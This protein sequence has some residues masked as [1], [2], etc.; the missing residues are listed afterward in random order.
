MLLAV[1]L[2]GLSGVVGAQEPRQPAGG[3]FL[4]ATPGMADPNFAE[5][6]VLL[7]DCGPEG[8]FGLIVN[9]PT[10]ASVGETFPETPELSGRTD[11]VHFGGPVARG[12]ILA[13]VAAG[14]DLPDSR[15]V[16]DG[17]RLCWSLETLRRIPG[18]TQARLFAGHSGWGPGQLDHEIGRGDWS[19]IPADAATVFDGS[20]GLWL[21]LRRRT[22]AVTVQ[23]P[24]APRSALSPEPVSIR[25]QIGGARDGGAELA[26]GLFPGL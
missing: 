2:T 23:A 19:I 9:K 16:I 5:T 7:I 17:V 8:A 10:G 26:R 21:R 25:F 4:L 1:V 6:V 15:R 12:R 14:A 24:V 18:H 3:M 13:L 22:S 11:P 20:D